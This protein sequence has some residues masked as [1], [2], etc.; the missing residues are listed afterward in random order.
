MKT[1]HLAYAII[2]GL[3]LIGISGLILAINTPTGMVA[4]GMPVEQKPMLTGAPAEHWHAVGLNERINNF[5]G[6][7]KK[8]FPQNACGQAAEQLCEDIKKIKTTGYEEYTAGTQNKFKTIIFEEY[9]SLGG[10][11]LIKG[12]KSPDNIEAHLSLKK[13][14]MTVNGWQEIMELNLELQ[15]KQTDSTLVF[16]KGKVKVLDFECEFGQ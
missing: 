15:G 3:A 16:N 1:N 5:F 11:T 7:G 13:M 12:F 4:P 8:I 2:I 10:I 14:V 6:A 9:G